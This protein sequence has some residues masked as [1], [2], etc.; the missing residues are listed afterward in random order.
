MIDKIVFDFMMQIH[1][2]LFD[3]VM[4]IITRLGDKGF[5]W[6]CLA[7]VL[8]GF[9]KS[10]RYGIA[11]LLSLLLTVI[12]GEVIIKPMVQRIRPFIFYSL[13]ILI[14]GPIS[15]SFPS[16]HTASS[17]SVFGIFLFAI[18][19]YRLPC[20]ILAFLIAFSR[21]YLGVHYFTDVVAGG[22]LGLIDAYIV[23]R[24]YLKKHI[25]DI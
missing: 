16:G 10:K 17:F 24:F 25:E 13:D 20:F 8:L 9:K 7:L 22:A 15:F 12:L 14:E 6:I 18:K 5:I 2:P 11:I 19:K 1:N 4:P 3:F 23:Y 21:L